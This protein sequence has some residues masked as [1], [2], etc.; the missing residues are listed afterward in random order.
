MQ[1]KDSIIDDNTQNAETYK[2]ENMN[3]IELWNKKIAVPGENTNSK[4]EAAFEQIMGND[5]PEM[6][7]SHVDQVHQ[8]FKPEN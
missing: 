1:I 3:I 4:G 8:Q 5:F 7:N 6:V 2:N